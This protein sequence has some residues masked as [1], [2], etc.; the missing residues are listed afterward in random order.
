MI[1]KL[2]VSEKWKMKEKKNKKKGKIE[3]IQ[4]LRGLWPLNLADGELKLFTWV[5]KKKFPAAH[6]AN[7]AATAVANRPNR[8]PENVLSYWLMAVKKPQ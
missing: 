7:D 3:F 8:T 6:T 5:N 1:D 4:W 2:R